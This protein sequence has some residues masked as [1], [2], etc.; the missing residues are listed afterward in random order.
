[1]LNIREERVVKKNFKHLQLVEIINTG[2][3]LDGKTGVITGLA[4]VHVIDTYIVTL[5]VSMK[6]GNREF[7]S[8][9][10]PEGCLRAYAPIVK[11]PPIDI[12]ETLT[13]DCTHPICLGFGKCQ[14]HIKAG[15]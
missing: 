15:S 8:V 14:G 12:V 6:V 7:T 3:V 9:V 13:S 1:M 4:A 11:A 5:P 2:S 10:M